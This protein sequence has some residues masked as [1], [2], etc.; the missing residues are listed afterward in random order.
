MTKS[1]F[2]SILLLVSFFAYSQDEIDV[3]E[4]SSNDYE[5]IEYD[6]DLSK[7]VI[8]L[9]K[10]SNTDLEKAEVIFK[11]ITNT[12]SYDYKLFNKNKRVKKF[13]CKNKAECQQ[14]MIDWKNKEIKKILRK[15]KAIC[16]GYSELY[17]RM[18][19]IAG[20]NC[21]IING[22]I[23]TDAAHVGR[24]GILDHAWNAIVIDN[25]YHYL[26]ATWASG[27]CTKKEN[28]KLDGFVKKYNDY[29]WLTPIDKLS[30]NHFPKDTLL[31]VN[32]KYNKK[33]FKQNPYIE[34]TK[35]PLIE[36]ISPDSGVLN[37]KINDTIK[38][39]FKYSKSIKNLQ[40]NTNLKRNPKIWRVTK[41]VRTIDDKAL[42]KQEYITPIKQNGVYSF[43]YVVQSNSLR[44]IEILF[45]HRLV[46]K[47]LVK[48]TE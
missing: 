17:K 11:W 32:S 45:E 26:D 27:Y 8:S 40:I 1:F 19:A 22:Y 4:I 44:Y 48:I 20:V 31:L 36:I 12:I 5:N 35:L 38:F 28:G 46:L 37:Q 3:D 2:L 6:G 23:K 33:L 14:K 13:R 41:G 43:E 39:S 18:C 24:M 15:K 9:T 42:S 16:W 29:Y 30:R 7:L 25:E 34:G 10:N 47:Y 21:I